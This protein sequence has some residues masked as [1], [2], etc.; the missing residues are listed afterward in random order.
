MKVIKDEIA[1]LKRGRRITVELSHDE[2]LFAIRD[3]AF[4]RL[5]GQVDDVVG[6]Y[7]LAEMQQVIWCSIEQVWVS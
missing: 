6:G 5:G 3:D 1:T 7:V 2:Q 4:Y